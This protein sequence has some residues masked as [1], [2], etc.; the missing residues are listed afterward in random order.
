LEEYNA[1]RLLKEIKDG[2]QFLQQSKISHR[3]SNT[4]VPTISPITALESKCIVLTAIALFAF[5][6]TASDPVRFVGSR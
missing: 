5:V 2:L 3:V 1:R 6:V 4:P